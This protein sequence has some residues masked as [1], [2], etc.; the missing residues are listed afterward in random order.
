M[1]SSGLQ[2]TTPGGN[3]STTPGNTLRLAFTSRTPGRKARSKTLASLRA[4]PN[5]SRPDAPDLPAAPAALQMDRFIPNRSA[6]DLDTASLH[7]K[8]GNSNSNGSSSQD[9]ASPSKQDY[10]K[11]LADSMGLDNS[12]RI[13][14][15]KQKAPAPPEGHDN[16]L[17]GL[18]TENLGPAPS[19]KQ[20]RCSSSAGAAL[21]GAGAPGTARA[22]AVKGA[23]AAH[24]ARSAASTPRQLRSTLL[25]C[26]HAAAGTSLRRRSASWT[27][28]T[29]WTTTTST[30]WTGAATAW[31]VCS[32]HTACR[33]GRARRQ[34][35]AY[36]P[37]RTPHP[38]CRLQWPWAAPC[39]S[40]TLSRARWR[41]CARCRGRATT[42]APWPGARMVHTWP[43]ARLTPRCRSGT[44]A[45]SSSCAS[46]AATPTA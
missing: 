2:P 11:L 21:R 42:S 18:Y 37:L 40:G 28:R 26:T 44:P 14:A 45:A 3:K 34:R 16:C 22:S 27:R 8:D 6:L 4:S 29:W 24:E 17:R 7:L 46:C 5:A 32:A 36:I 41:R 43:W 31:W 12:G 39:T 33:G 19:K 13:L 35:P 23:E 38:A 20:F 1:T 30:C 15:F 9:G 10:Q 25:P